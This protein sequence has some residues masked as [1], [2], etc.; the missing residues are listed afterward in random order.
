M[1]DATGRKVR[2]PSVDQLT[3]ARA[4][5]PAT[6]LTERDPTMPVGRAYQGMALVGRSPAP[7]TNLRWPGASS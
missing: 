5:V 6:F 1:R 4:C 7:L 3:R 2:P